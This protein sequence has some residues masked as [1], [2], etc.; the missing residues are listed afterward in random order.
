MALRGTESGFGVIY[1][2]VSSR[3]LRSKKKPKTDAPESSA[4]SAPALAGESQPEQKHVNWTEKG[5]NHVVGLAMGLDEAVYPAITRCGASPAREVQPIPGLLR[6]L[7][8]CNAGVSL[9]K[10]ADSR[11]V[12]QLR[13]IEWDPLAPDSG[14][15]AQI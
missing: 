3:E 6:E 5:P 13:A 14:E 10:D 1:P 7:L 11:Y 9:P 12:S 4:T 15:P 2:T 8:D